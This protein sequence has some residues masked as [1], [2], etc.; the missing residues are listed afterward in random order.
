MAADD[1]CDESYMYMMMIS[2]TLGRACIISYCKVQ[3]LA[4]SAVVVA[5]VVVAAVVVGAVVGHFKR[6]SGLL[7]SFHASAIKGSP[8]G[9]KKAW[10]ELAGHP[11]AQ[12]YRYI[13][14]PRPLSICRLI[15]RM[16]SNYL[17]P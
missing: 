3:R 1:E 8:K 6:L 14:A 10:V 5:A 7:V 11:F 15:G 12:T 13:Y 17:P 16:R 2:M 4:D 9:S